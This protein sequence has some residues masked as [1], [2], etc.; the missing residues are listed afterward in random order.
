MT[1][2][3]CRLRRGGP[4]LPGL[5]CRAPHLGA[6]GRAAPK[7]RAK[8]KCQAMRE[9]HVDD[10][11]C[12]ARIGAGLTFH[13]LQVSLRVPVTVKPVNFCKL[14]SLRPVA[15]MLHTFYG[16][17][18]S[19]HLCLS[20]Q[21]TQHMQQPVYSRSYIGLVSEDPHS[22]LAC[23]ASADASLHDHRG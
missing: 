3:G 9:G 17:T 23:R 14:L 6:Q 22:V 19:P 20:K 11:C 8:S 16:C 4:G 10:R 2:Q 15:L 5:P 21:P 1:S 12:C 18:A 7:N 13:L